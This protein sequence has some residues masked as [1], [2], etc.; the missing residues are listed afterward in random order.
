MVA[1]AA[2]WVA[3]IADRDGGV[4]FV[5]QTAAACP[6]APWMVPSDGGS[7]LTFALAGALWEAG[8]R[9]PWLAHASA[10]CWAKLGQPDEL[11]A[12]YVKFGLAF[13]DSVPDYDRAMIAIESLRSRIGPDGSMPVPGGTENECLTPLTLS[14][15]PDGRSRAL[16]TH[17]Q[18]EADLDLLEQ[19]QQQDGGWSFDWLPW[20]PGQ[21]VEWRGIVTLRAL[22]TLAAHGRVGLTVSERR[23]ETKR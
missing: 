9:H 2:G 23:Q 11:S 22:T 4:P 20:S 8:C 16:F 17:Q 13:L 10:W 6:H 14:P 12:Y 21:S 7:H 18:I 15:R 19:G 1:D 5:L 3:N